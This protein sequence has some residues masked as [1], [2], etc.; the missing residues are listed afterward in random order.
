[1]KQDLDESKLLY[2][3]KR[4]EWRMWLKQHYHSE[5]EVWLVFYK[6]HAGKPSIAYNE[7]VEEALCFGWIDSTVRKIDKD[8]YAQRFSPRKPR[9]PYSQ[10]NKERLR[11]LIEKGLVAEDVLA[12]LGDMI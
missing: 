5:K 8:R 4:Q 1:M 2:I 6:K 11:R 10:S 12:S 9:R 7:A 3:S